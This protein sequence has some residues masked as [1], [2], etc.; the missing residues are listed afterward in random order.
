MTPLCYTLGW[1]TAPD[2]AWGVREGSL[3]G[4]IALLSLSVTIINIITTCVEYSLCAGQGTRQS[5]C[6]TS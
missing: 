3:V 2:P 5:M 1:V 6:H 4:V